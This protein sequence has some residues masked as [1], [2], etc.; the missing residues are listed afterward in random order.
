MD[1]L[2]FS[3][4]NYEKEKVPVYRAI[5][6]TAIV[7]ALKNC[8]NVIVDRTNITRRIRAC[9]IEFGKKYNAKIVCLD[10]GKGNEESLARRQQADDGRGKTP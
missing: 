4:Y 8:M 2:C 1:N 3:T 10:F 9:Y 6:E 5:E 7:T